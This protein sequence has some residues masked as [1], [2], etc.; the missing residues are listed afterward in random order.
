MIFI[1]LEH[2]N[3]SLFSG[4]WE[5]NKLNLGHRRLV[6]MVKHS[7][8]RAVACTGED[9]RGHILYTVAFNVEYSFGNSIL[10]RIHFR[11]RHKEKHCLYWIAFLN[12]VLKKMSQQGRYI[13]IEGNPTM[14]L[15]LLFVYTSSSHI[16]NSG[17]DHWFREGCRN[18]LCGIGS[19]IKRARYHA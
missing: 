8:N 13:F 5:D 11:P 19:F 9:I 17:T 12:L 6:I 14:S 16:E 15:W 1:L 3:I 4:K 7:V 18:K 2:N 10:N